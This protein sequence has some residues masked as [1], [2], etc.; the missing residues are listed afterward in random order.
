[1]TDQLV[2]RNEYAGIVKTINHAVQHGVAA[3]MKACPS[4]SHHL[5]VYQVDGKDHLRPSKLEVY[6]PHVASILAIDVSMI[7]MTGTRSHP[8][9]NSCF[10]CFSTLSKD[11]VAV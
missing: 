1:M 10:H 9:T 3:F 7:T 5:N 6:Y 11:T 8:V 4:R 2:L